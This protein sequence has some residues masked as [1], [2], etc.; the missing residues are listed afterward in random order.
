MLPKDIHI[1]VQLQFQVCMHIVVI[2]FVGVHDVYV[3]RCELI[4]TPNRFGL[5]WTCHSPTRMI[6]LKDPTS[7]FVT[8]PIN[9]VHSVY[10]IPSPQPMPSEMLCNQLT[11][12]SQALQQAVRIINSKEIHTEQQTL[13]KKT[14]TDYQNHQR[15][16]HRQVLQRKQMIEARKEFIENTQKQKVCYN[17]LLVKV[18]CFPGVWQKLLNN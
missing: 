7:R 15:G 10:L 1:H 11:L 8:T 13:A 18:F 17:V 9:L 4:T 5:V 3:Y 2:L 16:D 12:M 14:S 6:H